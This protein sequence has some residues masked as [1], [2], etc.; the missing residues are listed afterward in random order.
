LRLVASTDNLSH[1]ALV[2]LHA[3]VLPAPPIAG[4][5]WIMA[6]ADV[7]PRAPFTIAMRLYAFDGKSFRTIWAPANIISEN[8]G[9]AVGITAD[10]SFIISQMPGWKSSTV[11]NKRY[12][13]AATGPRQVSQSTT[14]RR[15]AA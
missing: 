13:L 11:I 12:E 14:R 8:I 1:S 4:E 3:K 2:D 5:F 9:R 10:G 6:W 15:Y 7:P